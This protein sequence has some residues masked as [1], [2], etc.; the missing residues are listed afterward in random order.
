[1]VR[2]LVFGGTG[3]V[4][5]LVV[6]QLLKQPE[7]VV[8]NLPDLLLLVIHPWSRTTNMTKGGGHAPVRS[9][10]GSYIYAHISCIY[11]IPVYGLQIDGIV[12]L[13]Y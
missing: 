3:T 6:K 5:E 8:S 10:Q 1:M 7:N 2:V 11:N 12:Q 4:G 13:I 9:Q